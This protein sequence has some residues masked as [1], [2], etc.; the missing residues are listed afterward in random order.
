MAGGTA[1]CEQQGGKGVLPLT[2]PASP[3]HIEKCNEAVT[4][5]PKDRTERAGRLPQRLNLGRFDYSEGDE[6]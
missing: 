4:T 5:D 1:L 2:T 6:F 3:K